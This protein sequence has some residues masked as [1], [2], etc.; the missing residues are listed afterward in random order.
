MKENTKYIFNME[1][2]NGYVFRQ[3]F[4]IYDRLVVNVIPMYFKENGVTIR[5]GIID[6][7]KE[8]NTAGR[9][10]KIKKYVKNEKYFFL[11]M[12]M[13]CQMLISKNK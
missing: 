12:E 3:L 10:K 4:E 2:T 7:G 1:I 9:I 5:T 13:D 6:N 8:T 11:H